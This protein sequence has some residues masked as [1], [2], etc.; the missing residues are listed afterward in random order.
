M[1]STMQ[2]EHANSINDVDPNYRN[3][4][5]TYRANEGCPLMDTV[6]PKHEPLQP[7]GLSLR[8]TNNWYLNPLL[9]LNAIHIILNHCF[10]PLIHISKCINFFCKNNSLYAPSYVFLR[11]GPNEIHKLF[12]CLP[13]VRLDSHCQTPSSTNPI[14][15]HIVNYTSTEGYVIDPHFFIWI[16]MPNHNG[17]W[18]SKSYDFMFQMMIVIIHQKY[19]S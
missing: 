13:L 5:I 18:L 11:I 10:E 9:E 8:T 3:K 4:Q 16:I 17:H 6:V 14:C 7:I 2:I 19:G 15:L 1:I 12:S